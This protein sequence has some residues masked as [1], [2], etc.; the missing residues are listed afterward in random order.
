[1]NKTKQ[2]ILEK[3]GW[4]VGSAADF[5]EMTSEEEAYIDLKLSLSQFLQE[6]RKNRRLTQ[7]QMAKLIQSSQ[8]RVAKMEKA[9][10][11]VSIDLILRSLFA[12][13]AETKE[14]AKNLIGINEMKKRPYNKRIE[15]TARGR[16][17]A[18]LRKRP[19]G[20]K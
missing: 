7:I 9:E 5:L 6:K 3:N 14:I 16:H 13:G 18:R 11:S 4:K 19:A 10:S 8:S 1:M 2:E 17:G 15:L 12:L 20:S